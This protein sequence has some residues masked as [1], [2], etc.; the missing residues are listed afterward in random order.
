MSQQTPIVPSGFLIPP[1]KAA[2][3]LGLSVQAVRKLAEQG[4]LSAARTPGGHRRYNMR[5]VLALHE[6]SQAV[7][8][9]PVAQTGQ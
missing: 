4:K 2:E 9:S 7:P 3:I 1:S 5:E 8:L 6:A